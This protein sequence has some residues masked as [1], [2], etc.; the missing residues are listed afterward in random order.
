MSEE[1]P[2]TKEELDRYFNDPKS[3]RGETP[4]PTPTSSPYAET[5]VRPPSRRSK[6]FPGFFYNRISN[7][8]LAQA[9][10]VLSVFLG[11]MILGAGTLIT[12]V[13]LMDEDE[14]PSL[15][16]ARKPGRLQ[17]ATLAYSSDGVELAR[18]ALQNRSSVSYD[19]I[20]P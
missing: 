12:A 20:S 11:L 10:M 15:A 6:G 2:Y 8:K 9:T 1:W 3:R 19:E 16:A 14:L 4:P 5:V 17:L 18:Y 13:L 7:P